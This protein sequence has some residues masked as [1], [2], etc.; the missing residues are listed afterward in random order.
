MCVHAQLDGTKVGGQT[1]EF[2]RRSKKKSARSALEG[3]AGGR[4]AR[5]PPALH[6]AFGS[7]PRR[8]LMQSTCRDPCCG[9]RRSPSRLLY[10]RAMDDGRKTTRVG[11]RKTPRAHEKKN[12]P[13]LSEESR[14]GG[15]P[16]SFTYTFDSI[17]TFI[18]FSHQPSTRRLCTHRPAHSA[19][20]RIFLSIRRLCM[21]DRERHE[22][23]HLG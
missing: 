19:I 7:P 13:H 9:R 21:Y 10:A 2:P 15:S 23:P 12:A 8:H 6:A 3:A 20:G 18:I 17:D 5:R 16:H 1:K 4:G 14:R 11:K 22:A